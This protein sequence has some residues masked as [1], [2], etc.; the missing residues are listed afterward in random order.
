MEELEAE[1]G[2][3]QNVA[4]TNELANELVKN[5]TK[6]KEEAGKIKDLNKRTDASYNF[7]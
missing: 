2:A 4:S 5:Y 1:N 6:R 7:V 3:I